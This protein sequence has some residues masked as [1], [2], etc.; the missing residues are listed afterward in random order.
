M[1]P[2]ISI[3][4]HKGIS[5]FIVPF[6]LFSCAFSLPSHGLWFVVR[7]LERSCTSHLSN[8]IN[9]IHRAI[10]RVFSIIGLFWHISHVFTHLFDF[11]YFH[12][13]CVA[14]YG[15]KDCSHLL[16]GGF[17]THMSRMNEWTCAIP[18]LYIH[19]HIY[20]YMY[21]FCYQF[22]E[23]EEKPQAIF[24]VYMSVNCN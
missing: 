22:S 7:F 12:T 3:F 18:L 6:V 15:V 5:S 2:Q 1:A 10:S 20:E 8:E 4:M 9:Y 24:A 19:I 21:F 23:V 16:Y 14:Q 13:E 17:I 11:V